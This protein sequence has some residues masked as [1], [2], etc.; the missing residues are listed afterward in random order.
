M[1]MIISRAGSDCCQS[2]RY[3]RARSGCMEG[4]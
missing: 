2:F 1:M 4:A 3:K